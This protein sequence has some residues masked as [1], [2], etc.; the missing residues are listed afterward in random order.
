MFKIIYRPSPETLNQLG[1]DGAAK[2]SENLW[3]PPPKK[4]Y[5]PNFQSGVL[6]GG[7]FILM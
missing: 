1:T 2:I 5:R 4:R 7:Q 3:L 6:N